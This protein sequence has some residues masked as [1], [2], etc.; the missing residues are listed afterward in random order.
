MRKSVF[1]CVKSFSTEKTFIRN[2]ELPVCLN[3]LH[4]I[5]HENNYPYDPLPNDKTHGRCK[6]FG[7]VNIITGLIE[8]DFAKHCR[9]DN[10]KCGK[11]GSEYM[12]K[13]EHK[14]K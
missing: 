2:K 5:Q 9:D 14:E 10:L 11:T 12:Q 3:C 6:K 13:Q 4:F 8:Y 7:E 1:Q